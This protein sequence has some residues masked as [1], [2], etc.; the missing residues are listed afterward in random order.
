MARWTWRLRRR[1]HPSSPWTVEP[2]GVVRWVAAEMTL[3]GAEKVSRVGL[4][5]PNCPPCP[6]NGVLSA[7]ARLVLC[8]GAR[9]FC[10]AGRWRWPGGWATGP[11]G[12]GRCSWEAASGRRRP[13]GPGSPRLA[14]PPLGP[15]SHCQWSWGAGWW[16]AP[17]KG[18]EGCL[19]CVCGV[20]T[21]L[22]LKG[23][24]LAE[25]KKPETSCPCRCPP[26]GA[27][28]VSAPSLGS[29]QEQGP[30][31]QI[32]LAASAVAS[33]LGSLRAMLVGP[34]GNPAPPHQ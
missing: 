22:G 7:R 28:R 2:R 16:R 6:P 21:R 30:R 32:Y 29:S 13:W 12:R 1:N 3:P 14:P 18:G 23:T 10:P 8:R 27:A 4:K 17:L 31:V 33:G 15:P 19:P 11:A 20:Q 5:H 34:P 24:L 26:F 25:G 9:G